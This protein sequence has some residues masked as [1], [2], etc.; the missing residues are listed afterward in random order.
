MPVLPVGGL[1][2][3]GSVTDGLGG[4]GPLMIELFAAIRERLL[5][6]PALQGLTDIFLEWVPRGQARPFIVVNDIGGTLLFNN[7][8]GGM[9]F[10][11]VQFTVV[12]ESDVQANTLGWAAYD[13]FRPIVNGQRAAQLV[14]VGGTEMTRLP[15]IHRLSSPPVQG[16]GATQLWHWMFCYK[17]L[18]ARP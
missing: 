5:S 11:E 18:I 3:G 6:Q 10:Q 17:W 2:S 8:G 12:A 4:A 1:V 14:F 15:G 7:S 16:P 9:D 13:A